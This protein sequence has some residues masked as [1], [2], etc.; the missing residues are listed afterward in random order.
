MTWLV[1]LVLAWVAYLAVRRLVGAVDWP[2]VGAALVGLD[3]WLFAP[4]VVLLLVR[5][6][7]NAVP[8]TYY[9]P[10]L[11]LARSVQNDTAA[12]LLGT[13]APPPADVVV[14]V[15][16]FRSW[17]LDPVIGMT[18]VSLNSAKFYVIRFIA[19]VLGLLALGVREAELRQW[20]VA[21]ASLLASAA[22][23]VALVLVLRSDRLAA[24]IGRTAGRLVARVRRSVDPAAWAAYLVR[25]RATTADSLR[26]GLLPSLLALVAMVLADASIVLVC[27]RAFG[28]GP[29]R[30]PT[31]DVYA[32]FLMAY[33]LTLLPLFGFGVLDAVLVGSWTT[34]AGAAA[35]ADVVAATVV[36]RVVTIVGT[37]VLGLLSLALWRLRHPARRAGSSGAET[38]GVVPPAP[39]PPGR[40]P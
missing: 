5:Q 40:T 32:A 24:W 20:L 33:P 13:F 22:F 14:R 34:V 17:G 4:L 27:L 6:V 1:G 28:V 7:L 8:L 31:L 16:M 35:E 9:A 39:V 30:V 19:P 12:N 26:R 36:W 25:L 29:D 3:A 15:Q 2:A 18:G 38:S 23:L 10:G 37:F 21:L 11:G